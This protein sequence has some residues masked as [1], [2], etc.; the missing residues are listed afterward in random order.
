GRGRDVT[1]KSFAGTR[2]AEDSDGLVRLIRAGRWASFARFNFCADLGRILADLGQSGVD[3]LHLH[4]PNPTMIW[5][6]ARSRPRIPLFITYH[7][8]A[9]RQRFL[10]KVIRPIE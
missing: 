10:G 3:V 4:V 2:T 6:L 9:V 1:W 5:A 8:D 7:S